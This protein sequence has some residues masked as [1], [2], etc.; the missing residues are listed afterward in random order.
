M[1]GIDSSRKYDLDTYFV[2]IELTE[3]FPQETN[4]FNDAT[5]RGAL[6]RATTWIAFNCVKFSAF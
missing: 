4:S 5:T 6:K 3:K 2:Q 1:Q